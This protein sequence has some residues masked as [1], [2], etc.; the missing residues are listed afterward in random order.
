MK[1]KRVRLSDDELSQ[2]SVALTMRMDWL[3]KQY[4]MTRDSYYQKQ[5]SDTVRAHDKITR[6]LCA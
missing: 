3:S 6:R 1:T 4:V 5:W 2:I